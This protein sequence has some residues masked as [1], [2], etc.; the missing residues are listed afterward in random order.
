MTASTRPWL[1]PGL[2]MILAIVTAVLS[3]TLGGY[4]LLVLTLIAL[5]TNSKITQAS[6]K[7][8][9]RK[10]KELNQALEKK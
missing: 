3:F 6:G 1:V 10:K 7:I 8:F 9:V 4:G 2:L 5:T